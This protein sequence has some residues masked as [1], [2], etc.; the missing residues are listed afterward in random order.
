M[1]LRRFLAA[2]VFAL[3]SPALAASVGPKENCVDIPATSLISVNTMSSS[4]SFSL[5]R[6]NGEGG[7]GLLVLWISLTDGDTSITRFDTTCTVS[8]DGNATDYTPQLCTESSGTYACVDTGVWQKA[9]P[10]TKNWTQRMDVEGFPDV[11]CTF[12]VGTGSGTSDDLLT[13]KGR[14]CTKG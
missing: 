13:V 3:A 12:S 14:L 2:V 7:Y 6:E 1:V 5:D 10:G 9:S 11:Q 8:N 4:R